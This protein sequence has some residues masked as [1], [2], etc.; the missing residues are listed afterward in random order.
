MSE[1]HRAAFLEAFGPDFRLDSSDSE[2]EAPCDF[3][4]EV[5]AEEA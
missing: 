5:I 3:R 1:T 4:E 2:D